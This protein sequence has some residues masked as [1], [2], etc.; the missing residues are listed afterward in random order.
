MNTQR[1]NWPT[2]Y[3][4]GLGQWAY[5]NAQQ[6][7]EVLFSQIIIKGDYSGC[8]TIRAENLGFYMLNPADNY[9]LTEW[10]KWSSV[11]AKREWNWYKS[12]S[13]DVSE[14]QKHAKTW[15]KMHSGD[16]QVNSNYGWQWSRNKQL[17]KIIELLKEYP[18]TRRAYITLYDG[19]EVDDYEYDTPCTLN[20]GFKV[21]PDGRLN[22]TVMMRSCD[23][24]FGFCNDQFC[25]SELQKYVAE[26]IGKD[27]GDYYHFAQ[28]MHVYLP[29]TGIYPSWINTEI[30]KV[31]NIRNEHE[32]TD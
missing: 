32:N 13:R 25:F 4:T 6:A 10:R 16:F 22:M 14:L 12:H 24:V 15:A 29:S 1:K 17:Q 21:T 8:G 9:I 2:P 23:L 5:K 11:Y 30:E 31:I 19:K 18:D 27:V 7:F 26:Q 28:D 20:V 3:I